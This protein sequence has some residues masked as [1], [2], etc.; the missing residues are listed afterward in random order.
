MFTCRKVSQLLQKFASSYPGG[1]EWLQ[2]KYPVYARFAQ[3]TDPK[4]N[5]YMLYAYLNDPKRIQQTID[6]F[7]PFVEF[8]ESIEQVEEASPEALAKIDKLSR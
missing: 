6:G 1:K 5:R 8:N 3:E 4:D 2:R 7:K